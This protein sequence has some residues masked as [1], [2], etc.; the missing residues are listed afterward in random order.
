MNNR[1]GFPPAY[2]PRK[3]ASSGVLCPNC[4]AATGVLDSRRRKNNAMRRRRACVSCGLRFT[5]F[6]ITAE[7]LRILELA[8]EKFR[9][10]L[11]IAS[12]IDAI[13]VREKSPPEDIND[14]ALAEQDGDRE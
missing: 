3:R 14:N 7:R 4:A 11:A 13:L 6:E 5:T 9:R 1:V 2:T 8:F 10:V 12:E